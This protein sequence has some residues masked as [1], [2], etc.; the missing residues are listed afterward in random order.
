MNVV[1]G[2]AHVRTVRYVAMPTAVGCARRE[3]VQCLKDWGLLDVVETA[4]LLVSELVTNAVNATGDITTRTPRYTELR[5]L[6]SVVLQLR[7]EGDAL[8]VSVWDPDPGAPTPREPSLDSE[9]GRG[10]YLVDMI[11]RRWGHYRPSEAGKVV[12]CEL[13]LADG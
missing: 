11:S 9:G 7:V 1:P 13:A 12:W 10:L 2:T 8:R 5:Q 4:E 3:A 6:R